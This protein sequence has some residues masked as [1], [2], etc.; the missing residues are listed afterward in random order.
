MADNIATITAVQF[1]GCGANFDPKSEQYTVE[2]LAKYF[3]QNPNRPY[4]LLV[5]AHFDIKFQAEPSVGVGS[6]RRTSNAWHICKK[7]RYT[8]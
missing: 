4:N 7:K 8:I 3:M 1:D 6:E 2:S 5:V